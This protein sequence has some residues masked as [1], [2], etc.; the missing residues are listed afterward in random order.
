MGVDVQGHRDRGVT[1]PLLNDLGMDVDCEH[2]ARGRVAKVVEA[3]RPEAC[4]LEQRAPLPESKP[5]PDS[6]GRA[7]V[8]LCV[9]G[10]AQ[11]SNLFLPSEIF[12]KL[13]GEQKRTRR[14]KREKISGKES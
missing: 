3:D 13:S 5:K 6:A 4:T 14:K 12:W 8:L 2:E 1:Q 11:S 10:D 9:R 7:G